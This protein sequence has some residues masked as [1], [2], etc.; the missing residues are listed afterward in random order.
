MPSYLLDTNILLRSC[1]PASPSYKLTLQ[2]VSNLL[3]SGEDLSITAQNLI[4][5][6]A[7]VTRPINVNGFGWGV[8]TAA[9]QVQQLLNQFPLLEDTSAVFT[10]WLHL[11]T[12]QNI[13]GK[14]V[15]DTRLVAVMKAHSITHLL[16]FNNDDFKNYP[17]I[18]LVHPDDVV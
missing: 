12:S 16:T 9:S 17:G 8:P 10:H 2:A 7:V 18:T 6:W 15:H 3:A 13:I 11:V 1:D 5:F 14:Q 4:E